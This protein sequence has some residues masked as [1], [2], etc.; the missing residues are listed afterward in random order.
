MRRF[1]NT[2]TS[3]LVALGL[4]ALVAMGLAVFVVMP[5]H[6]R[7]LLARD[8]LQTQ[9]ELLARLKLQ[10]GERGAA[11][12][13]ANAYVAERGLYLSGESDA[14]M[15]AALQAS[16]GAKGEAGGWRLISARVLPVLQEGALRLIGIEGRM[17]TTIEGLQRLLLTL[18]SERPLLA[19]TALQVIP[20]GVTAGGGDD[21]KG[22]ILTVRLEVF[23]AAPAA[24]S[25]AGHG[26]R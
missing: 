16:L 8:S 7:Y 3:R 20:A 2:L 10:A 18:D 23:G 11:R 22:T 5:L 14:V 25:D 12:P 21:D 24:G 9:R 13:A 26:K 15:A 1:E 4:A 6:E 17:Q 19:V